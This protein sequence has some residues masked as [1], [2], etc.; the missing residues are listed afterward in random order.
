MRVV[1][2]LYLGWARAG[3]RLS[4]LQSV[5][6][7]DDDVVEERGNRP[8]N[9]GTFPVL[10]DEAIAH[11]QQG[12]GAKIRPGNWP[13]LQCCG[14]GVSLVAFLVVREIAFLEKNPIAISDDSRVNQQVNA[15]RNQN[16][17]HEEA[18][19]KDEASPIVRGNKEG[20]CAQDG[21][22]DAGGMQLF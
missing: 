1:F 22:A 4:F 19:G 13:V 21:K 3:K 6:D 14:F 20:D 11:V 15:K 8:D 12:N 18:K 10:G 17:C 7:A 9:P 5:Q 2:D 16:C